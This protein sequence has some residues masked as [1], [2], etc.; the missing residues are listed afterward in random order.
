MLI[1]KNIVGGCLALGFIAASVAINARF[2][3]HLGRGELDRYIYSGAATVADLSKALL[4]VIVASAWI[5]CH[6]LRATIGVGLFGVFAFYSLTASFGLLAIHQATHQGAHTVAAAG[7]ADLQTHLERLRTEQAKLPNHRPVATIAAEVEAAKHHRRWRSTSGCTDATASKSRVFCAGYAR[8]QGEH[9]TAIKAEMAA[10]D[11]K[12]QIGKARAELRKVDASSAQR[13]ADP[14]AAAFA[15]VVGKKEEAVRVAL[16]GL[17]AALIE[18]GSCFGLFVL[19]T[20]YRA[21]GQASTSR[22]LGASGSALSLA[23]RK[24]SDKEDEDKDGTMPK[25]SPSVP[26]IPALESPQ[27]AETKKMHRPPA[28]KSDPLAALQPNE[29][30][31][32]PGDPVETVRQ[33][34]QECVK[35][36]KGRRVAAKDAHEHYLAWARASGRMGND[37]VSLQMFGRVMSDLPAIKKESKGGRVYYTDARLLALP[38]NRQQVMPADLAPKRNTLH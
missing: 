9:A 28:T 26:S 24:Y 10:R 21:S 8:L 22:A 16:H 1:L 31:K 37:L 6:R 19:L 7:W 23:H 17:L 3:W 12:A 38:K 5:T 20:P 29:P 27:V 13:S 4:P 32:L 35:R 11:L 15:L 2:G 34:A 33:W 25:I 30:K 14:Q 18:L 36:A